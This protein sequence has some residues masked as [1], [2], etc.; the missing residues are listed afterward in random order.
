MIKV[1]H[2]A[3]DI[4]EFVAS[5]DEGKTLA[6]ISNN[7]GEKTTTCSNIVQTM[8][9]RNY[10]ERDK[11]GRYKIGIMAHSIVKSDSFDT[12]LC[13]VSK[14]YLDKLAYNTHSQSVLS[15]YRNGKK[16]VLLR[17]N[18]DNPVCINDS[19]IEAADPYISTTGLLLLAYRPKNEI[20]EM[21]EENGI[22]VIFSDKEEFLETLIKIKEENINTKIFDKNI[23]EIAAPIYRGNE[24]VAAI[25][26]FKPR[27]NITLEFEKDV[28]AK[29]KAAADNIINELN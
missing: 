10:L 24:V 23:F 3:F 20:M 28:I 2:K 12:T 29:L 22:P 25:G 11:K 4:L 8:L 21:I 27:F 16:F 17:S 14:I 19:T 13:T 1:L 7:I 6:S 9:K 5:D 15:V 18:S 26:L